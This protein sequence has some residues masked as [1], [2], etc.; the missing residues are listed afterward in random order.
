MAGLGRTCNPFSPPGDQVSE[1]GSCVASTVPRENSEI[2]HKSRSSSPK[3]PQPIVTW[4]R[5]LYLFEYW[6]VPSRPLRRIKPALSPTTNA[7]AFFDVVWRDGNYN[8]DMMSPL[9]GC[10]P[11]KIDVAVAITKKKTSQCNFRIYHHAQNVYR[12][13]MLCVFYSGEGPVVPL[14]GFSYTRETTSADHE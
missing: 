11:P 5:C 13:H 2:K 14:C 4:K 3:L 8:G 1:S 6:H 9:S 12:L 10:A 7:D